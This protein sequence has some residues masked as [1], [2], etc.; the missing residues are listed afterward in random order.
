M[1][2]RISSQLTDELL[3]VKIYLENFIR[4]ISVN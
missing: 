4:N 3:L 2:I 1:D